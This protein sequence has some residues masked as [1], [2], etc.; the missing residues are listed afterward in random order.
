MNI[1]KKKDNRGG[2]RPN[3]GGSRHRSGRPQRKPLSWPNDIDLRTRVGLDRFLRHMLKSGWCQ[4]PLDARTIGAL[5][6]TMKLLLQLRKW[7][8]PE[9]DET[10]PTGK[11][12][13]PQLAEEFL[14]LFNDG[15]ELEKEKEEEPPVKIPSDF[16]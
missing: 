16:P 2:P 11:R 5:N 12:R 9:I 10:D 7:L 3:S 15:Y 1:S 6:G 14:S 8:G 4:N 13:R